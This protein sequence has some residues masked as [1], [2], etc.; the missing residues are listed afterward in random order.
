MGKSTLVGHWAD[1]A[2]A[3]GARVLLGNCMQVAN[4]VLPYA[5][6]VEVLRTLVRELGSD[7]VRDLLGAGHP[8][9]SSLAPELA[10]AGAGTA[11]E[12]DADAGAWG[13]GRLF[14]SMLTLLANLGRRAPIV[15]V[16][17][18]LHWAD[19]ATL[20]LCNFLVRN[21]GNERVIIVGTER[22]EVARGAPLRAW[23]AE[24]LRVSNVERIDVSRFRRAEV[25][26]LLTAWL[27]RSPSARLAGEIYRRSE[28]NAFFAEELLAAERDAPGTLPVTLRDTLLARFDML[29][30]DARRVV[31]AIAVG[32]GHVSHDLLLDVTGLDP[33]AALTGLDETVEQHVVVVAGEAYAF[34]HAAFAEAL[35]GSLLPGER[36]RL[37]A[38]FASAL[39]SGTPGDEPRVAATR[40]A[41]WDAAGDVA[42]ALPATIDAARSARRQHAPEQSARL[43]ERALELW[44]RVRDPA[45]VPDIDACDLQVNA[46]EALNLAGQ[47]G[48][49]AGIVESVLAG[50]D[51]GEAPYLAGRLQERLGWF[52]ARSGDDAGAIEAYE[53]AIAL[54]PADPPS[55]ERSLALAALGRG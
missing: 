55:V 18:D 43:W 4:T 36:S 3:G 23:T 34:R 39:G 25:V 48:R 29:S 54:V 30:P 27:G 51:P 37:H 19:P 22:A 31:R 35:Y 50:I 9:V 2:R 40:A 21:L 53:R 44:Q 5:P 11:T 12:N 47:A 45:I 42:R 52:R 16:I 38:A 20:D 7:E 10:T 46:A 8:S 49:A 26:A 24:L 41:D 1:H 28:G 33:A 6:F 32:G 15:L 17:E 13:Q 14:E